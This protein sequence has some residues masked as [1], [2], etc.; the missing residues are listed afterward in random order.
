MTLP[1]IPHPLGRRISHDPRSRAFD[2]GPHVFNLP[3]TDRA[4]V[5]H[6]GIRNQGSVGA[7]VGFAALGSVATGP[8]WDALPVAQRTGLDTDAAGYRLYASATELDDVPGTWR[9]DGT[10]TDTGSTGIGGAKAAQ[11]AGLIVGYQH[12]FSLDALAQGLMIGPMIVGT[13]WY[14]SMFTT[15]SSGEVVISSGAYVAG[16]HEYLIYGVQRVTGGLRFLAQNSWGASWGLGGRFWLS[17]ATMTRL[18]IEQGD[19]TFFVPL[20]SSPA[21]AP[22]NADD[23]ALATAFRAWLAAKGL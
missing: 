4:W 15:R 22:G 6:S 14:S 7:C 1:P 23:L 18:L 19:A 3:I 10:G 8:N 12:A 11:R 21:P 16:G 17:E 9:I 2:I 20:T 13:N 5:N